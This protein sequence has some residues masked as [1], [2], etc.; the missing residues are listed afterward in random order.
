MKGKGVRWSEFSAGSVFHTHGCRRSARCRGV[1]SRLGLA[2]D[3]FEVFLKY[4]MS[5]RLGRYCI[6][7]FFIFM[8][9]ARLTVLLFVC[10]HIN[11]LY[12]LFTV[13]PGTALDF[14]TEKLAVSLIGTWH[15]WSLFVLMASLDRRTAQIIKGPCVLE[16]AVLSSVALAHLQWIA[17]QSPHSSLISAVLSCLCRH[18]NY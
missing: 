16:P 13:I 2:E 14:K 5:G 8:L 10:R 6:P 12:Q 1:W 7:F 4:Q 9:L 3:L 11:F 15:L 18:V 17:L